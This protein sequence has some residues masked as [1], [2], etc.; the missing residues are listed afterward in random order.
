MIFTAC[1]SNPGLMSAYRALIQTNSAHRPP[2]LAESAPAQT[3]LPLLPCWSQLPLEPESEE[4]TRLGERP[5]VVGRSIPAQSDKGLWPPHL[6][7][8][9]AQILP[10]PLWSESGPPPMLSQPVN[11]GFNLRMLT[12]FLSHVDSRARSSLFLYPFF[13]RMT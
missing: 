4:I 1:V 11:A 10:C 8:Y 7:P 2:C 12:P 13:G 9:C 5:R 6:H 3:H